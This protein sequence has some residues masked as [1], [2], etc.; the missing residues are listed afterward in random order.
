MNDAKFYIDKFKLL[1]HPE[2]GF[3]REVYRSEGIIP[4]GSVKD[5][6]EDRNFAT[7][8]YFLLQS[9]D[10][11]HFHRLKSDEIWYFHT[12]SPVKIHCISPDGKYE[13]IILGSETG[14]PGFQAKITAGT[15]FGA[16]VSE[17]DS[18]TLISCMV[19]PG[20]DF[21]D[22]ELMKR[23]EMLELYPQHKG[24]IHSFTM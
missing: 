11:S 22:F 4:G 18:F 19:A 5:Y 16:E 24:I 1:P 14:E 2:G 17:S 3:F 10:K 6:D 23:D 9:G 15:I 21:E 7:S 13:Q 8:I 12:G 20:F